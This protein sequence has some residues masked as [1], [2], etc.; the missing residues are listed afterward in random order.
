MS[1]RQ[2]TRCKYLID[3]SALYPVL[4]SGIPFNPEQLAVSYLTEYEIGNVLWK[5]GK[6][7]KLKDP[8][9]IAE[10]FEEAMGVLRKIYVDSI[11]NVLAIALERDLTF[12]DASYAYIAE[13]EGLKLIT[14]DAHLLKKCKCAINTKD[15]E[16]I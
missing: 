2:G 12:Y 3:A 9:Q 5:E 7:K 14:E 4:L 10:V 15:V 11:V 8:E 16:S 6:K 1:K 13:K